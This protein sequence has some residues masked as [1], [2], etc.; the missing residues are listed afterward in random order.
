MIRPPEPKR[1]RRAQRTRKLLGDA[2]VSLIREKN[3]ESI[4]VQEILDRA[5]IGRST[6][7]THY[8][9]KDELLVS[10]IES[11]IRPVRET[12]LLLSAKP[13]ERLLSFSLPIL[14]HH[15]R[16]RHHG[17]ERMG[18]RS[19]VVLHEHL[20][21]FLSEMIAEEIRPS[22]GTRSRSAVEVPPHLVVEYIVSTFVLVLNWWV[23]SDGRLSAKEVDEVFRALVL[24]TVAPLGGG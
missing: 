5:N 12:K 13:H 21:K 20:R 10:G 24:P 15:D 22:H 16:H 11:M 3:Y 8:R 17:D 1:D 9:D 23:E 7:Y 6:F 19:R 18:E 2:L 4:A 14:E